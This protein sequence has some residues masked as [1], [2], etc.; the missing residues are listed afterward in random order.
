MVKGEGNERRS[1]RDQRSPILIGHTGQPLEASRSVK[2][3]LNSL[4]GGQA[5]SNSVVD[6]WKERLDLVLGIDDLDHDREIA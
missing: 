2:A 4:Y 5:L 6:Q 1:G 3:D